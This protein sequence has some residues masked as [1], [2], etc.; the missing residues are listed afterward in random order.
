MSFRKYS[1]NPNQLMRQ[2][3]VVGETIQADTIVADVIGDADF[4]DCL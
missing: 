1:K 2:K 3:I 4:Y